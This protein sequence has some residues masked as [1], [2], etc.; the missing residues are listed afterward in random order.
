MNNSPQLAFQTRLKENHAISRGF[1]L[2]ELLIVTAIIGTLTC[3]LMPALG[4]MRESARGVACQAHLRQLGVAGRAY[5]DDWRGLL[6]PVS[7]WNTAYGGYDHIEW[8]GLLAQYLNR[9]GTVQNSLAGGGRS[10]FWGCPAWQGRRDTPGGTIGWTSPGYGMARQPLLPE[11]DRICRRQNPMRLSRITHQT[12]RM[13]F[14]DAND[15]WVWQ[16]PQGADIAHR[17]VDPI[18]IGGG[19]PRHRGGRNICFYDGR[20]AMVA[21]DRV[22]PTYDDPAR[23]HP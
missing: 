20:V 12:S 13:W 10:V 7:W 6:V 4:V 16:A 9:D 14:A 22:K 21:N 3:L 8:Y 2:S 18:W 15:W 5:G 23:F 1:S 19:G 17:R 11:D